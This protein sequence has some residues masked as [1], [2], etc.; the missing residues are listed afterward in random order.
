MDS[1]AERDQVLAAWWQQKQDEVRTIS[2][3]SLKTKVEP[4]RR[5]SQD[6]S[7]IGMEATLSPRGLRRFTTK[8]SGFLG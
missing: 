1:V 6:L 5:G 3:L 2:W 7:G 8:L 4:G